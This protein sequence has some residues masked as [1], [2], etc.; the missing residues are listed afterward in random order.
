[1]DHVSVL[2][3]HVNLLDRLD[4]LNIELLQRCLKL[5]V[6]GPRA[7]MNLL[8]LSSRCTLASM[9]K[10]SGQSRFSGADEEFGVSAMVATW[11]RENWY[12]QNKLYLTLKSS[13]TVRLAIIV[14]IGQVTSAAAILHR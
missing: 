7:L 4:R 14:K 2:L 5:L 8:H 11:T 1:M 13:E 3:E 9:V 6:I 10:L 12:L